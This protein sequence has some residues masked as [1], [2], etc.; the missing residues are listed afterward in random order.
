[1]PQHHRTFV[2]GR[3]LEQSPRRALLEAIGDR[4]TRTLRDGI[5]RM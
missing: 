4:F 3:L 5:L 2:A 1:M